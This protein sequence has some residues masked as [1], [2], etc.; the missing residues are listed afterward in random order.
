MCVSAEPNGLVLRPR[1]TTKFGCPVPRFFFDIQ[2]GSETQPDDTGLNLA[3]AS[4]A[5]KV[6]IS[7]LPDVARTALP[8]GDHHEFIATVRDE[9]GRQIFRATL[10]L[11]AEWLIEDAP[12][13][14]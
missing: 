11:S 10:S 14:G 12:R 8:D 7:T 2:D 4:Q 5:R 6:A 13:R 3:D 1:F 9:T